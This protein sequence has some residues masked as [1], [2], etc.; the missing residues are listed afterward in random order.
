MFQESNSLQ[1]TEWKMEWIV[2][3]TGG[4]SFLIELFAILTPL[5]ASLRKSIRLEGL[6]YN[7]KKLF[8]YERVKWLVLA[9]STGQTA[10]KRW[11][12][13]VED[14]CNGRVGIN[15]SGEC[16]ASSAGSGVDGGLRKAVATD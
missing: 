6:T 11:K 4:L 3:G 1:W 2:V 10:L 14:A 5:I 7:S 16:G 8:T 15:I 13:P 12:P 9:H